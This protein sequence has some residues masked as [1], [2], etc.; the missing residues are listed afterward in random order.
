M[1]YLQDEILCDGSPRHDM[2]YSVWHV[3]PP[4]PKGTATDE[5]CYLLDLGPFW[6]NVFVYKLREGGWEPKFKFLNE[7]ILVTRGV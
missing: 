1:A 5:S 3:G 4:S 6:L 7:L 2:P